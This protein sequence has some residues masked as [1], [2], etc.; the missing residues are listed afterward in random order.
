MCKKEVIALPTN[1]VLDDKLIEEALVIG[2]HRT[3]K[4][5]VSEALQEYI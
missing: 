4:A 3:K 2:G 5:V 1:L